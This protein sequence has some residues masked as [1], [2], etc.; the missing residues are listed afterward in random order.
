MLNA[1]AHQIAVAFFDHVAQM[2]ADPEFYAAL[3]WRA[4]VVFDKA[5]LHLDGAGVPRRPRCGIQ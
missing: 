2:N 5:V 4:D 1:I 3:R